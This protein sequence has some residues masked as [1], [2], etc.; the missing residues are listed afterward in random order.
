MTVVGAAKY[1][2]T[3]GSP[4]THVRNF[5]SNFMFHIMHGRFNPSAA[6]K[7]YKTVIDKLSNKDNAEF[8]DYYEKLIELRIIGESV[9]A[10]EL[11]KSLKE[12]FLYQQ[13]YDRTTKDNLFSKQKGLAIL[14]WTEKTYQAEDDVHKIVNDKLKK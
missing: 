11:K 2:K 14:R 5:Y 8:R 13:D 3:I 10:N 9:R 6:A 7:T 12:S 1:A 4:V